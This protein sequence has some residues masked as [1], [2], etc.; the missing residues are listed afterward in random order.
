MPTRK[1]TKA[2]ESDFG[3]FLQKHRT[4]CEVTYEQLSEGLCS[5]SELKRIEKGER[6][7]GKA[8]RDR[9]LYR[10][11][12]GPDVY[13]NF[14]FEEDY[15]Q[16]KRRQQLLY[17]I[18]RGEEETALR[19]LE[20]YRAK[21]ASGEQTDVN[22]RLERQFCLCMEA[23]ILRSR[24]A[25][26]SR[27]PRGLEPGSRKTRDQESQRTGT[28]EHEGRE[29]ETQGQETQG[30]ET[31][32]KQ[33]CTLFRKAL[34]L[35]AKPAISESIKGKFYSIQE[36]DLLLEWI[37]YE[38][39]ST[40]E[41]RYQEI[42]S[43]VEE[44]GLDRVNC[45]KIYPK[46]VYYLCRDG[47]ASGT[48]G[49][50]EQA[51]AMTLCGKAVER[52]REAGRLYY[53]WELLTLMNGF[54]EAIAAGQRAVG[55]LHKA[56]ELEEQMWKRQERID[57]L[58]AVYSEFGVSRETKDSCWLYVENEVYCINE[59][60]RKRRKML[61]ITRKQICEE[62]MICSE[63][64]LVRLET[65]GKRVQR[66]VV[67]NLMKR[68]N[69]PVEYC[70]TELDTGDPVAV[71]LMDQLRNRIRERET[72]EA[73]QV[74]AQ[75]KKR[76]SLD[77][78]SNRQEW[79]NCRALNELYKGAITKEQCVE[80][81]REA[82]NCTIP[83]EIAMKQGERYLTNQEINCIHNMVSYH[84]EMDEEKRRQ[85]DIL[86]EQYEDYEGDR[87][88]FCFI[89]RY[90]LVLDVVASE[91]GDIG[92]YDRSDEISRN[93][94]TECLYQRRSY[95]VHGGI[96]NMKWNNDQ[97]H[98]KGIPVQRRYNPEEELKRCIAFSELGMDK[99]DEEFYRRK[100]QLQKE[101]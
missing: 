37:H 17:E 55:A 94:I 57:A 99:H 97:R 2:I 81:L 98:K 10:L 65:N 61:G 19:L 67:K 42:L 72:A 78:P 86:E 89:N 47:L 26:E 96:Y 35:T 3:V 30:Q 74:L 56:E 5:A 1:R 8:L 83:Y 7:A 90:E 38:R 39:P 51:E 32:E 22:S 40:W 93:I 54:A 84:E 43:A 24:E 82:L 69:L 44:A 18:S 70:R 85:I 88:I 25:K 15:V 33:L 76:I 34:E 58:E 14:L 27:N 100:L 36:L 48:L 73:D 46:T 16:W 9:L 12:I 4:M 77:I 52:L 23:Q 79:L 41:Q 101:G 71:E 50:E 95:G 87:L 21:Y 64:T 62:E 63:K 45:A 68:L 91:L 49:L 6:P 80:Q 92:E 75:L 28:R 31:L 20:E 66:E 53:M 29:R 59:I 60:I 11:G 13:E